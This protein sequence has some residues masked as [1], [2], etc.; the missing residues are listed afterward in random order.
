MAPSGLSAPAVFVGRDAELE[1]L[2]AALTSL[3]VAV[4]YGVAGM[5]K[6]ALCATA[7]TRWARSRSVRWLGPHGALAAEGGAPILQRTLRVVPLRVV[8]D[9]LRRALAGRAVP[10]HGD[11]EA[12]LRD[13]C[14]RLEKAR[15]VLVLDDIHMLPADDRRLLLTTLSRGLTRARVIASSRERVPMSAGDPDR[16][17]LRIAGLSEQESRSLWRS[18]DELYGEVGGF[19]QALERARGNPFL[20]RRAHAGGLEDD[21]PIESAV[22]VLEGDER[23]VA[24]ALALSSVRLPLESLT[25]VLGDTDAR[26]AAT[27]RK[28]APVRRAA[29]D[30]T[31]KLA[32]AREAVRALT[33]KLVVDLDGTGRAGVHD[34]FREAIEGLLSDAE[35]CELH[36]RLSHAMS[37]AGLDR[38]ATVR[39][40]ARHLT[41]ARRYDEA[42]ALLVREGPELVR[43]AATGE[44]LLWLEQIPEGSRSTEVRLARARCLVRVHQINR[45]LV[46]LEQLVASGREP[47]DEIRYSYATV[48]GTTGQ[49]ERG[50]AALREL[51]DDPATT[52]AMRIQAVTQLAWGLTSAGRIDEA[53]ERLSAAEKSADDVT[54][55]A[56]LAF[57]RAGALWATERHAEMEAALARARALSGSEALPYATASAT[58]TLLSAMMARLGR[59]EEARAL[60]EGDDSGSDLS[61]QVNE[62]RMRACIHYELGERLEALEMFR[63]AAA[64]FWSAGHVVT[65]LVC[66]SWAGR[67][68]LVLGRRAE[69]LELLDKTE[70]GARE[71]G[72]LGTAAACER[73]KRLD[74]LSRLDTPVAIAGVSSGSGPVAVAPRND[75][76]GEAVRNAALAALREAVDGHGSLATRHIEV[77]LTRAKG[78]GYGLDRAMAHLARAALARQGGRDDDSKHAIDE[79][80][81]AASDDGADADIVPALLRRIGLPARS[82]DSTGVVVLDAKSH[83]LR[84]GDRVISL[85]RRGSL[86]RLLYGFASR[87]GT[88][89]D[90]EQLAH[91]LWPARY[92]PE[93][94]DGAIWV[95]IRRLRQLLEGTGM[96]VELDEDGYFLSVPSDFTF[97]EKQ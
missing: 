48:V 39:E 84:I 70:R 93:R 25:E 4:V 77:V 92:V 49:I 16:F 87:P 62:K 19:E 65:A 44:L 5:G 88:V 21:S 35:R 50:L 74:P 73:A 78:R 80:E 13:L 33:T 41:L 32:R 63:S 7:A 81:H 27:T 76:P 83:E 15:S 82:L 36:V 2:G 1:R 51:V 38:P 34:L 72:L 14:A 69:A 42:G 97:V 95:N 52:P 26:A 85:K 59:A 64:I 91:L 45:A 22:L 31:H 71:R 55:A 20:L 56:L 66:D 3:P 23:R 47:R 8:A 17:E 79:A 67:T 58:R 46:E 10:E 24:E 75:T 89:M 68:L 11:D 43:M 6:S 94:H 28:G 54:T 30:N 96:H 90:K 61:S 29:T 9:D 53:I 37:T 57:Y 12:R 40:A 18:L 60:L 86:R